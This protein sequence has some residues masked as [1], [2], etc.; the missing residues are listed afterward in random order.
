METIQ[1]IQDETVIEESVVTT[2][3][4]DQGDASVSPNDMV[5][6]IEDIETMGPTSV[7]PSAV[8]DDEDLWKGGLIPM[9]AYVRTK[10]SANALRQKRKRER[11]AQNGARQLAVLVPD[12]PSSR[13]ALKK[14]GAA[15][16]ERGLTGALLS[17]VAGTEPT[18]LQ[19]LFALDQKMVEVVAGCCADPALV[20][21]VLALPEDALRQTLTTVARTGK[22][23]SR[24]SEPKAA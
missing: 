19:K 13:E 3:G 1:N 15:M 16:R 22:A 14:A 2:E 4:Q 23:R 11:Q 8:L 20:A 12:D 18:F 21:Q 6:Y 5:E 7:D 10:V 17:Q 24:A 9:K